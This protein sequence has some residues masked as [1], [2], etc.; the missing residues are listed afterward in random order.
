VTVR[1]AAPFAGL[2]PDWPP[3]ATRPVFAAATLRFIEMIPHRIG[4]IEG[5]VE[6]INAKQGSPAKLAE[7]ADVAH[8]LA[9]TA[10][11]LGMPRIGTLSE[12]VEK[13]IK[14]G[15]RASQSPQSVLARVGPTIETLLDRLEDAYID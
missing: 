14:D 1:P 10:A 12:N 4:K 13:R 2:S 11:T 7:I 6:D 3:A 9:G 8:Q 5:L 15:L